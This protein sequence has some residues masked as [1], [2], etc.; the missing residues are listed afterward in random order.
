[1]SSTS[2]KDIMCSSEIGEKIVLREIEENTYIRTRSGLRRIS[3]NT[4]SVKRLDHRQS[5]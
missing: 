5:Q 4:L 2:L 1:M 3:S